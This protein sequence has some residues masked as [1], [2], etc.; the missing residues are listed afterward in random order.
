MQQP[1]IQLIVGLGNPGPEYAATRHN[2]GDWFVQALARETGQVLRP[3]KKFHGLYCKVH[4]QGHD[5]HLLTPTTF[6]N[7]SGQS[8]KAL[9]DFFKI[10]PEQVLV[11]HDELDLPVGTARFKK[12]GGHGGHNGLRDLI[13]HLGSR[14]FPR[15]RLGI[16]HPGNSKLVVN[17]VLSHAGK[18]E[19]EAIDTVIDDAI[20]SL[21]DLLS[22]DWGRAMNYLH[23]IQPDG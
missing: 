20:R 8:V 11:A 6:M 2:A 19:R 22:G 21:P 5:L 3:E 13:N 17:Y 7:R 23:S 12:S 16:G 10:T 15:L 9:C 1:S 4:W 14:D 18:R